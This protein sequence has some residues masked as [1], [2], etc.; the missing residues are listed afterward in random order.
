MVSQ[1]KNPDLSPISGESL[2]DPLP[3]R[4]YALE[5]E[6]VPL[7]QSVLWGLN[8]VFWKNVNL[9][10]T[11]YGEHYERSLPAHVSESHKESFVD[12]S[13]QKFIYLLNTLKRESR[14]PDEII[15]IEQGPGTGLYAKQFLD[16]LKKNNEEFYKRI[17]F[18]FEDHSEDI[19]QTAATT[20]NE[21]SS[22]IQSVSTLP[23]ELQHKALLIRHGNVWDQ[24]PSR[25]LR[26][27][28]DL[29]EEVTVQAGVDKS[30][31]DLFEETDASLTLE[32]LRIAIKEKKFDDFIQ[33]YPLLWK[34]IMQSMKLRTEMKPFDSAKANHGEVIKQ[35]S[36]SIEIPTEVLVNNGVLDNIATME[37]YIDWSRDGYI[38][39]VDLIVTEP[40]GFQKDRRP[41]KYDGSLACVVNGLLVKEFVNRIGKHCSFDQIR[42][43]NHCVTIRNNSLRSLLASNHFVMMAEVAVKKN[44]TIDDVVSQVK[45]LQSIGVDG[46]SFS[47]QA[48]RNESYR[49]ITEVVQMDVFS[50]ISG[51]IVLPIIKTRNR[52]TEHLLTLFEDLRKQHVES[53]FIVTG[54]PDP[55]NPEVLNTPF[56]ILPDVKETFFAGTVAHPAKE[57]MQ[58][59]QDKIKAGAQFLIIQ[60]SY[61]MNA[62]D[63]WVEEIKRIGIHKEIPLIAVIIPIVSP[64]TIE[65]VRT[66]PDIPFPSS[67]EEQFKGLDKEKK[68][69]KGI[70]LAKEMVEAYKQSGIISG[71]YFYTKSADVIER[72]LQK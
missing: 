51:G 40:E 42:Y 1:K 8:E 17:R 52:T 57:R 20:N 59:I 12:Y 41:K 47:D 67:V 4:F 29:M 60:A 11:T 68:K 63:E 5:E 71:I 65:V 21:H 28:K 37:E 31:I 30:L 72:I 43:L 70:A 9:W 18:V 49:E 32:D 54:D 10:E 33:N 7:D 16:A 61:D 62:W 6:F 53:L 22:H 38:E 39:V 64:R 55:A 50:K 2:F 19:L 14:L 48:V 36:Q 3:E 45:K 13:V 58:N 25:L 66:I 44:E 26:V 46:L 69:K 15:V 35:Y 56:S 34:P 27:S 23:E 24:L